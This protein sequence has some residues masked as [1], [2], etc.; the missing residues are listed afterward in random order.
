VAHLVQTLAEP[1]RRFHERQVAARWRVVFRRSLPLLF[2]AALIAG[3]TALSFLH[4]PQDSMMLMMIFNFPP[5]MMLI[6][7]GMR[8]LP[9]FEIPPL[10]R[11]SPAPSW[12]PAA[13]EAT[14]SPD[15]RP[16]L[17]RKA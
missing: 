11:P 5:L 9:R 1:P 17:K 6:M 12:L 4:I 8:E 16:E 14:A 2:C 13:A 7:F 15:S 10:P 3:T